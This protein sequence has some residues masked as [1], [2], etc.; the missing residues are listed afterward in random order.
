MHWRFDSL[1]Y[2]SSIRPT[3]SEGSVELPRIGYCADQLGFLYL[4]PRR[5]R[6]TPP[7][8]N[9]KQYVEG[10]R[11]PRYGRAALFETRAGRSVW[12]CNEASLWEG[13]EAGWLDI[14][15]VGVCPGQKPQRDVHG[16]GLFPLFQV[17]RELLYQRLLARI[18]SLSGLPIGILPAYAAIDTGFQCWDRRIGTLTMPAG[19]LVRRAHRRYAAELPQ[20]YSRRQ[21]IQVEIEMTLR[22]FGVT[23]ASPSSRLTRSR[24]SEQ[25]SVRVG[26]LTVPACSQEHVTAF[27]T[28]TGIDTE[29]MDVINLQ[30]VADPPQ[31]MDAMLV[32]FGQFYVVDKFHRPLVSLVIDRPFGWGG[33]IRPNDPCFVQ[34]DPRLVLDP[35]YWGRTPLP[36]DESRTFGFPKDTELLG[37]ERVGL[38][39]AAALRSGAA[40]LPDVCRAIDRYVRSGT[41][42]LTRLLPQSANGSIR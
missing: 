28:A 36:D 12:P 21:R 15:G 13:E 1:L 9:R 19:L 37:P 11:P 35:R 41:H 3:A 6:S 22:Q 5:T 39:L 7:P 38:R 8:V 30:S 17:F 23:S 14:K 24:P 16:D 2:V 26:S 31:G 32:D 25:V 10:W 34:P 33:V 20:R 27:C 42:H 4:S 18:F 40:S 29:G